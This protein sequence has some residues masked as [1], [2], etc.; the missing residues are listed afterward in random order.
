[1]AAKRGKT[2]A[3]RN[4]GGDS[5]LPGWAWMVLGILLAVVAILVAP[6][7]LKSGGDGFFRPQ[8]NPD[9]QPAQVSSADEEAIAEDAA[10]APSKGKRE[11]EAPTKKDTDYDF[12]TLLPGR[13]VP[14]SDA[15]LAASEKAEAKRAAEREKRARASD[16]AEAAPTPASDAPT[17]TAPLPR[18]VETETV[19]SRTPSTGNAAAPATAATPTAPSKPATASTAPASPDASTASSD[20][21]TRY[22]LQAGAFQAS[23]QAEEMKARIAMLGLSARVESAAINGSTVYRVR[24]GPY[25]T[26]S[27]L[28]D[29]KRKLAGGGLQAMAIKVK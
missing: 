21:G 15:E 8:P 4:S 25:G 10:P 24:M 28:A 3:R 12:Y 17:A 20:D 6:K 29:A 11:P 2:Q 16:E 18:P 19:P 14:M 5:S 1:M 7:Y 26:A 27:D 13:E 23:G 9:A 22:L